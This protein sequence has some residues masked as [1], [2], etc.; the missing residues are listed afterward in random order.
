MRKIDGIPKWWKLYIGMIFILIVLNGLQD[1]TKFEINEITAI[2]LLALL[3]PFIVPYLEEFEIPGVGKFKLRERIEKL[4]EGRETS[5]ETTIDTKDELSS[6]VIELEA[7]LEDF[8]KKE[9]TTLRPIQEKENLKKVF[10]KLSSEFAEKTRRRKMSLTERALAVNKLEQIG[11]KFD[12][13]NFLIDK[14]RKGNEGERVGAAASLKILRKKEAFNDLLSTV[15]Y[16]GKGGSYVRYRVIEALNALL[17]ANRLEPEEIE[18]LMGVL[19]KQYSKEKNRVVN[20]Y[21][22]KVLATIS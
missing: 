14:L 15:S 8:L 4:E 11:S 22:G 12:D 20:R 9:D 16:T 21:I 3:I 18:K 17:K 13:F 2:L 6:R 7:K 19:G 10:E 1:L 5:V